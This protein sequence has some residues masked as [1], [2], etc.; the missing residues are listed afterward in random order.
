MASNP[1]LRQKEKEI[2]V[3]VII[4]TY[5]RCEALKE[6]LRALSHQTLAPER[7]EVLVVDNGCSD[8][9]SSFLASCR[10]ACALKTFREPQNVGISAARNIAIRNARGRFI[11]FVSDDLIV[12]ENF[13]DS[14]VETLEEFQGYWVVGGF[15]QLSSLTETPFGRYLDH[16]EK[17][18]EEDRKSGSLGP[19]IWEMSCPTARNLSVPRADLQ[20]I[21]LFDEQFR[22]SCED[23]DLAHRASKIG[24]RFL[25]NTAISCLHNDQ[26]GELKRYC[27]AQRRG[28]HDTVF[29]CAKYE[30]IHGGAAIA[31]VNGY[32]SLSD[33]PALIFKKLVKSALSTRQLLTLIEKTI[34]LIE[35]IRVSDPALWNLYRMLIGLYIFR[36]WREGL[37]TLKQRNTLPD[38]HSIGCHPNL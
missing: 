13:I 6:T 22:N 38:A 32:V 26:S 4:T 28:A 24:I 21:G 37:K 31:R 36:G 2:L 25:Y 16:L 19:N 7:Y 20:R 18:F 17:T 14:H 30:A 3:S 27:Q 5:N 15:Q 29:F 23:Q 1:L 35:R 34:P 8:A 10:L 11:I 9:T 12:P 33:G